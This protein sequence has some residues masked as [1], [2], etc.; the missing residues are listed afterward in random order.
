MKEK[1]KKN[2]ILGEQE[3]IKLINDLMEAVEW[4]DFIKNIWPESSVKYKMIKVQRPHLLEWHE[5]AKRENIKASD[6]A[7]R[8]VV[9]KYC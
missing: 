7:N 5:L 3:V 8:E 1:S 6:F 9:I 2:M 4:Q